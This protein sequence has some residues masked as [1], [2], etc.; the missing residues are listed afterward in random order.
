VRLLDLTD[1]NPPRG[2]KPE[3]VLLLVEPV[4][5]DSDHWGALESLRG[6]SWESGVKEISAESLSHAL[7]GR[8]LPLLRALGREPQASGRRVI[9]EEGL[10]SLQGA[11]VGWDSDMCRPGGSK[12]SKGKRVH[13]PPDCYSPP[14]SEG[15]SSEISEVFMR[16]AQAW[17]VGRY[18]V[19]VRGSGFNF[20]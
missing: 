14:L 4:S 8:F 5:E 18:V 13:G 15:A 7:H 20:A 2:R 19:V 17:R 12:I 6:T 9:P 11:C 10:C 3:Q 16:V 1:P